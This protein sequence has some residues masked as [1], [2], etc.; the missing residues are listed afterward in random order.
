MIITVD[1]QADINAYEVTEEIV[2]WLSDLYKCKVTAAA[3]VWSCAD[4]EV[5]HVQKTGAQAS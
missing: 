4:G 2:S 1:L 5:K 3:S